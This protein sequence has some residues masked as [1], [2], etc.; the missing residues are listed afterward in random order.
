MIG[1]NIVRVSYARMIQKYSVCARS[2]RSIGQ[3]WA[4]NANNYKTVKATDFQFDMR[5]LTDSPDI[6]T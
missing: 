4:L 5:I 1:L 3:V 6:M 2:G